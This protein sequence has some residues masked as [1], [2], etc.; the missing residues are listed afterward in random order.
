M[1]KIIFKTMD[2]D[3]K[4]KTKNRFQGLGSLTIQSNQ[5]NEWQILFL[6][7]RVTKVIE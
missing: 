7:V 6:R 4:T 5:T 1:P 2:I 3:N